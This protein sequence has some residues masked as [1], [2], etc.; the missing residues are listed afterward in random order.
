[1]TQLDLTQCRLPDNASIFSVEI[2]AIDLA[3]GHIEQSRDTDFI[4]FFFLIPAD[5]FPIL[6]K[7]N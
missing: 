2:K 6:I 4:N 1:M 3:L 5:F 7:R